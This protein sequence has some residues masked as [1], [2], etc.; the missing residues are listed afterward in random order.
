MEKYLSINNLQQLKSDLLTL[1]ATNTDVSNFVHTMDSVTDFSNSEFR[2][3]VLEICYL[4]QLLN[5][6]I[7]LIKLTLQ[8]LPA[9]IILRPDQSE[10]TDA[11]PVNFTTNTCDEVCEMHNE[12]TELQQHIVDKYSPFTKDGHLRFP[13]EGEFG[14]VQ[15]VAIGVD[16][17]GKEYSCDV[18]IDHEGNILRF[19]RGPIEMIADQNYESIYAGLV[20]K[21]LEYQQ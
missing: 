7:P 16:G 11:A 9:R 18:Q 10:N 12:F 1:K 21:L 14:N 17:S 19:L 2:A 8:T 15:F 6:D 13:G 20:G 5:T 4:L 3:I